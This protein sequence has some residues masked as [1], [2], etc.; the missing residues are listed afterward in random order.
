M[1]KIAKLGRPKK[2]IGKPKIISISKENADRLDKIR[3]NV[4]ESMGLDVSYNSALTIAL[5]VFESKQK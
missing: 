5:R 1:A 4:K 2:N 3:K